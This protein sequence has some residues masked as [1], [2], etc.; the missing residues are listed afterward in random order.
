MSYFLFFFAWQGKIQQLFS[1][2]QAL[3]RKAGNLKKKINCVH[4]KSMEV[5]HESIRN[6]LRKKEPAK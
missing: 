1:A 4:N 3:Q 2:K 6:F 5:K